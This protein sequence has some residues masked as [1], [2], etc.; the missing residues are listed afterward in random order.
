MSV[1]WTT[2]APHDDSVPPC[3]RHGLRYDVREAWP[4]DQ[5][6]FHVAK[7]V[8]KRFIQARD[9]DE[10]DGLSFSDKIHFF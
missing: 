7:E 2:S 6:P 3:E 8:H 1:L 4:L 5:G 9:D 10:E